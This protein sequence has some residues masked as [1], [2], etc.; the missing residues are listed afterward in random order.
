MKNIALTPI[1]K[2]FKDYWDALQIPLQPLSDNL[3][4]S[5]YQVFEADKVKYEKYT[6]AIYEALIDF[7]TQGMECCRIAIL[8][9]GRGP[10]VDCA[11]E[12]ASLCDM[13]ICFEIVE[14]NS[15]AFM[16]LQRRLKGEWLRHHA[17]H[18]Y[19][20]LFSDM[21]KVSKLNVNIVVSELLGSFG[22]NELAPECLAYVQRHFADDRAVCI[23]QKYTSFVMPISCFNVWKKILC[24]EEPYVVE[25]G[26]YASQGLEVEMFEF[27]LD[28]NELNRF[29][30]IHFPVEGIVDGIAGFFEATLYRSKS[31]GFD[32]VLSTRPCNRTANMASWFPMYFPL[33]EPINSD[34]TLLF[35]RN[36]DGNKVW[37]EW[38]V[39]TTS[40]LSPV[41][42]ARGCFS[43]MNL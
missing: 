9:A 7:K 10:L 22:D 21:R 8:G 31:K 28:C 16:T 42:N 35:S 4:S 17:N 6:E 11:I 26:L 43:K 1:E 36:N 3:E 29:R 40:S 14:K 34:F 37:Y 20:L 12:A 33:K 13:K 27:S 2:H 23:P 39:S 24:Y 15:S 38:A 32:I 25:F 19:N 41:H 5:T 30:E 18:S